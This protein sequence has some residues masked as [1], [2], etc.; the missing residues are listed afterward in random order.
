[1]KKALII[2]VAGMSSSMMAAKTTAWLKERGEDIM[3]D[4]VG[5]SEGKRMIESS[6]FVLFLISPQTKMYF[7]QL[8]EAG[9]RVSKPVVLIPPQAYIPI[10]SGIQNLGEFVLKEIP[11]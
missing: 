5:V 6:D 9:A 7:E 8:K 3:I 2:C 1:M 10:P 11:E 4:A